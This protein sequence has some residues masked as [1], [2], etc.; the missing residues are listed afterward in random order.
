M[1]DIPGRLK[2]W[3]NKRTEDEKIAIL[4]FAIL[5]TVPSLTILFSMVLSPMHALSL[6]AAITS[7]L[8]FFPY[9]TLH[10]IDKEKK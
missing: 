6:S 9:D 10:W 8:L 3:L 4:A 2:T 7:L 5:I 1:K